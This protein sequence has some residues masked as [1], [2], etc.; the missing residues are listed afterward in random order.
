MV[1]KFAEN[2]HQNQLVQVAERTF[3]HVWRH[4]SWDMRAALIGQQETNQITWYVSYENLRG[5]WEESGQHFTENNKRSPAIKSSNGV[6]G[7]KVKSSVLQRS[8]H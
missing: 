8:Q 1:E 6:F 3:S 7:L 5:F 4:A 2:L